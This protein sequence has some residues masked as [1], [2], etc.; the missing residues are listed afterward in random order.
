MIR[1]ILIKLSMLIVATGAVLALGW[2]WAEPQRNDQLSSRNEIDES[3]RETAV[4]NRQSGEGG[5]GPIHQA[6]TQLKPH[7]EQT[8]WVRAK[9]K[10]DINH[11]TVGELEALPGIGR[12]LARRIIE[13]RT[14]I[15]MFHSPED[16][17]GVKGLGPKRIDQLRP[18]IRF[19]GVP[20]GKRS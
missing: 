4:G 13:R 3:H 7:P 1:S 10:L 12:V 8:D 14:S 19:D 16:L 6:P 11:S 9:S 15:G 18:L 5:K 20:Q 17:M 2:P